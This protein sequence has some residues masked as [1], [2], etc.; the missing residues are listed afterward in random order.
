MQER[1]WQYGTA[2]TASGVIKAAPGTLKKLV[3]NVHSSGVIRLWDNASAASG[4]SFGGQMTL[5]AGERIVEV[6]PVYFKNGIYLEL[7]SGTANITPVYL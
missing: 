6:G 1:D 5:N 3:I 4:T 7:V 2:L